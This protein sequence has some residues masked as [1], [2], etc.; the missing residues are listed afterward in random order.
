LQAF[1]HLLLKISESVTRLEALLLIASPDQTPSSPR[2]ESLEVNTRP[3]ED[4]VDDRFVHPGLISNFTEAA[5]A[6][7]E[8]VEPNTYLVSQQNT[9]NCFTTFQRLNLRS[10]LL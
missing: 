8:V 4:G 3:E 6:E 7:S 9:L 5:Q 10:A 2:P 1:L